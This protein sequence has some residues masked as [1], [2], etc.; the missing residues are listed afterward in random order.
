M[1][2]IDRGNSSVPE[3]MDMMLDPKTEPPMLEKE[4][5]F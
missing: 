3:L 4:P 2:F 5:D 1:C